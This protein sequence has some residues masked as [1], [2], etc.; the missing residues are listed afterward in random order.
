M[1]RFALVLGLASLAA[2]AAAAQPPHSV[3]QPVPHGDAPEPLLT[4]DLLARGQTRYEIFCTPCHGFA[5]DGDGMVVQRGFP[6]P[7]S[8]HTE[9]RRDMA[10][11]RIVSAI[12][13]GFGRMLPMAERIPPADRWAIA[14]YVKALQL[15]RQ[16]PGDAAEDEP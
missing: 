12:T 16:S 11:E 8:F 1:R 4:R 9:V 2:V 10:P 3:P 6:A 13:N 7:P 14:A 15:A 5:G